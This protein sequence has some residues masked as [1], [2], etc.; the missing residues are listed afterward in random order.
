M[1]LACAPFPPG[2]FT[3]DIFVGNSGA[4]IVSVGERN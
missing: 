3:H 4:A 2:T 1:M